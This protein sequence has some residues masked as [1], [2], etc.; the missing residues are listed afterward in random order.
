MQGQAQIRWLIKINEPTTMEKQSSCIE[1]KA[2][3]H[4]SF[5]ERETLSNEISVAN[6][7]SNTSDSSLRDQDFIPYFE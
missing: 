5:R 3:V 4:N 2:N 1:N 6:D 7:R